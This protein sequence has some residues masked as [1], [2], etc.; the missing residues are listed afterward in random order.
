MNK[1]VVQIV[2]SGDYRGAQPPQVGVAEGNEIEFVNAGSAGTLLVLTPATESILAAETDL[3]SD[4][5]WRSNSDIYVFAAGRQRLPR[6]SA[7]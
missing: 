7:A 1:F 6:T 2:Q 5:R 3:A 4:P